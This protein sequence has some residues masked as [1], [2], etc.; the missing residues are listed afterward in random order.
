MR[1]D[2]RAKTHTDGGPPHERPAADRRQNPAPDRAAHEKR[3]P[4]FE[5]RPP[6]NALEDSEEEEA[7][8]AQLGHLEINMLSEEDPW[9]AEDP[10]QQGLKGTSAA[11]SS[12]RTHR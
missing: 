6:L 5:R 3:Q 1:S 4:A 10:W 12:P 2:C 8:A 9:D 7:E 11:E